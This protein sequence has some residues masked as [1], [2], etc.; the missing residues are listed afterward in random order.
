MVGIFKYHVVILNRLSRDNAPS[1]LGNLVN[2]VKYG[3]LS[4]MK[5]SKGKD[6]VIYFI[7]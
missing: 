2:Q 4:A 6:E 7:K 3:A 5:F 1:G